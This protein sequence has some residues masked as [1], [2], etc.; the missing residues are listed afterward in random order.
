MATPWLVVCASLEVQVT[1]CRLNGAAANC[2]PATV[3]QPVPYTTPGPVEAG[4]PWPCSDTPSTPTPRCSPV[5]QGAIAQ[6]IKPGVDIVRAK[7]DKGEK[8]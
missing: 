6:G 7:D 8:R 1:R 4:R 3:Q 2:Q 5:K